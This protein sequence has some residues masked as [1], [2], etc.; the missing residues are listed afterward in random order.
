MA[1]FL[2]TLTSFISQKFVSLPYPAPWSHCMWREHPET[3]IVETRASPCHGHKGHGSHQGVMDSCRR[4]NLSLTTTCWLR[5]HPKGTSPIPCR[6]PR[7]PER[8]DS[9]YRWM[10]VTLI[11]VNPP[12]ITIKNPAIITNMAK[13]IQIN[14]SLSLMFI[15]EILPC[16]RFTGE[17]V[18]C[19]F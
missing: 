7:H 11:I 9:R 3:W 16:H 12:A 6:G 17:E 8:R 19:V 2:L 14:P 1:F 13:K 10:G 5:H 4:D 15:A 18:G